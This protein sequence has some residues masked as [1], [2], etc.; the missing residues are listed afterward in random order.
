MEAL[1][2]FVPSWSTNGLLVPTGTDEETG[3]LQYLDLSYIYPY[4][5]LLKPAVTMFNQLQEGESTDEAM[6]KRLLDGG[7]ISMKELVKPF[8]QEAIYTCTY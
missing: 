1:R 3:N 5:S 8:L 6:T 7:I 4:E 2:R